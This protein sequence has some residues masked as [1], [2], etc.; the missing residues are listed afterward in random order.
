M[1]QG[2]CLFPD[3]ASAPVEGDVTSMRPWVGTERVTVGSMNK[4]G[5]TLLISVVS[6]STDDEDFHIVPC[7]LKIHTLFGSISHN[8]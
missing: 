8:V 3:S 5:T 4:V 7:N 2:D 6:E 1:S